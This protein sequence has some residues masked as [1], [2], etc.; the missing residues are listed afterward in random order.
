[1]KSNTKP[2]SLRGRARLACAIAG[3]AIPG[4]ALAVHK[5]QV[6]GR[7]VYQHAPCAE[8]R[9]TVAEGLQR[10]QRIEA[11]HRKLD[12]L[13]ARG[14]GMLVQPA[15]RARVR[16]AAPVGEENDTFVPTT[17]MEIAARRRASDEQLQVNTERA[18]AQ[19]GAQLTEVLNDAARVCGGKLE[20]YP[21]LGMS[22]EKFRL[23]TLHARFGNPVQVVVAEEDKLALRLYVF[24]GGPARRVYTVGGV[25]T[26][27]RP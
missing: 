13:Q 7:V 16:P 4:L 17:K 1:V 26:A 21:R 25:V 23:C 10:Q 19:A 24:G 11:L 20:E 5:C 8:A 9:E 3:A 6:E 18:N 12:E 14:V 22:D 2:L 15:P 27:I